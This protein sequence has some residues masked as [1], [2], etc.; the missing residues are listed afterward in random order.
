MQDGLREIVLR[1]DGVYVCELA[2]KLKRKRMS[3]PKSPAKKL[4]VHEEITHTVSAV[5][6]STVVY[7]GDVSVFTEHI[8]DVDLPVILVD[9]QAHAVVSDEEESI[10]TDVVN[11]EESIHSDVVNEEDI[12]AE[13]VNEAWG[14]LTVRMTAEM[15][16]WTLTMMLIQMMK[17]MSLMTVS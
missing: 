13:V 14:I 17:G 3:K 5:A 7:E 6:P 8:E 9:E 2:G 1:H 10:H 12:H 16:L 4:K 11:E 15:N